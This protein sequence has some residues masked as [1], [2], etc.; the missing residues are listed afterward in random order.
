MADQKTTEQDFALGRA[1]ENGH[2]E[3]VE[4]L[5]EAGADVHAGNDFA[6]RRELLRPH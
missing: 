1:S 2:T 4:A 5:L 3:T 6:L